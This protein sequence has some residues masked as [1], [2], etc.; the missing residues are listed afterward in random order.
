MAAIA[1]HLLRHAHAGDPMKWDADDA[2]RPLT[3]KGRA[4]AERLGVLLAAVGFRTDVMLT[5]PK[6]RAR[7]TADLVA[8]RLGIAAVV[9]ER[10]AEPLT[11]VAI[12]RILTDAGNP[13]APTLVGHDPDFSELLALLVGAIE[14]PM[15]KGAIARVDV[16]R[17]V[18]PASGVLRW[19]VPP[20]LVPGK[21]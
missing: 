10:L 21:E 2:D 5:S 19:L 9:D 4:Q 8:R 17:P 6:V 1:L 15:K 11:I 13:Q 7:E 12:E 14:L 3:A 20:D 18:S 16:E